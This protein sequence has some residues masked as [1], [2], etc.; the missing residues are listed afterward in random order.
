MCDKIARYFVRDTKLARRHVLEVERWSRCTRCRGRITWRRGR[1]AQHCRQC[2][3]RI[4]E[5]AQQLDL[6]GIAG[7]NRCIACGE[8]LTDRDPRARTCRDACRRY[9]ARLRASFA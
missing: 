6:P 7:P 9:V 3:L 5:A 4:V 8:P 2:Q 1:P